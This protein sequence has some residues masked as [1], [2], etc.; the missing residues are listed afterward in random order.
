MNTKN[1]D[2]SLGSGDRDAG[3]RVLV[4]GAGAIGGFYG[5]KLYQA[6]ARVS[7]LCRS[8]FEE[9]R[10]HGIDIQSIGGN[11]K[12]L[13]EQVIRHPEEYQGVPDFVVVATKV[14]PEV[15][16][17]H[18]V[19]PVMGPQTAVV[20]IQNGL[21]IEKPFLEAF[22]SHEIISCLA[23]ISVRRTGPAQVTHQ[24][25]GRLALGNYPSGASSKVRLLSQWFER[26]GVECEVVPQ[27]ERSRWQKLIWNASFNPVSVL[28]G[29]LNTESILKQAELTELLRKAMRE[30]LRLAGAGGYE[31]PES[32]IQQNLDATLSMKPFKTSMLV[33]FE[34]GRPMEV[35]A[36][37]GNAVRFAMEKNVPVP[38]LESLHALILSVDRK[39]RMG[40]R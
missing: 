7:V 6:G 10:D 17:V 21:F 15:N 14:L 26:G 25:F 4:V 32:I 30:V 18:L 2:L 19:R 22:P 35:E 33:D 3:P 29:A 40:G 28:G 9:V 20:L 13:P 27:V 38:V 36:I 16:A 31:F 8:H 39:G 24:D 23:F 37:L 34:A 1:A 5:A 11:F 12:F